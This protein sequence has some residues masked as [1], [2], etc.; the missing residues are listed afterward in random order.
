MSPES[1]RLAGVL[2]VALPTV[3]CGGVI[4]KN[5]DLNSTV[6]TQPTSGSITM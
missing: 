3:V 1:R 4:V 2:L 6:F 5:P